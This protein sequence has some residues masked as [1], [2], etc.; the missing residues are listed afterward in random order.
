MPPNKLDYLLHCITV[1]SPLPVPVVTL[2]VPESNYTV[3]EK[4]HLLTNSSFSFHEQPLCLEVKQQRM[5]FPD[6]SSHYI[7]RFYYAL[8]SSL[9]PEEEESLSSCDSLSYLHIVVISFLCTPD[10]FSNITVPHPGLSKSGVVPGRSTGSKASAD[11]FCILPCR[12]QM[13]VFSQPLPF[14]S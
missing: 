12:A 8:F 3:F 4:F 1:H 10:G 14:F 6:A 7:V 11:F 13:A 5:A 2:N 9:L